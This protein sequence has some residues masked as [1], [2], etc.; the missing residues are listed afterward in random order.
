M[1]ENNL[2]QGQ[3]PIYQPLLPVQIGMFPM[4]ARRVSLIER[5]NKE[6]R[7]FTLGFRSPQW[8]G[9]CYTRLAGICGLL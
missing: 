2:F 4:L 8:A 3:R 7:S 5:E 1:M 6:Y 9:R